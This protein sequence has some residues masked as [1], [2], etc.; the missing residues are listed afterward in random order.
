MRMRKPAGLLVGLLAGSTTLQANDWPQWRGPTR[1]GVVPAASAPAAWPERFTTAWRV[2]VGEGYSS[3][4]ASS[5][6]IFVHARREADETVTALD[7]ASGEILWTK[8][9]PAAFTKN[10]YATKMAKGPHSTPVVASGR[11]FTLGGTGILSA[12]S[13]ADGAL[14]WRR[15]YSSAVDTSKLF[16]GTAMSPLIDAGSLVVQVGSDVHG[17]RVI[18][19]DPAT[20]DARW[21]WKGPGPG[22]ASPAV[23][24]VDGVRQIVAMTDS[25]IVGIDAA[26]GAQLWL[27]PFADE[28]HENIVSPIWTGQH[29]LVSGTRQGTHAYTLTR[30]AGRWKV[31]EAWKS[32]AVAFYMST[33][34]LA[35]GTLYGL[36]NKRKGQFVAVDAATGSLRWATEGRDADHASVLVTPVH[37]LFLTSTGSLVLVR[38]DAKAYTEE[39]RYTIANSATWAVPLVLPDGLIVRDA[40]GVARLK[41]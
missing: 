3:P 10:S 2:E 16:C 28:W 6:R 14:V 8:T 41:G 29:L 11:V 20:G 26:T 40:T 15:D 5:G 13:T 25:S 4:V 34:V 27:A 37:V 12:W 21:T 32:Q 18:A 9:Y 17:G 30:A 36:S 24:T 39:R 35:D 7:Q 19:L 23:I 22:Y 33:P 38:R 1:D 31:G